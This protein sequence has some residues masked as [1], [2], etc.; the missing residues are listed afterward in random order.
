MIGILRTSAVGN[1]QCD[2]RQMMRIGVC[3][4]AWNFALRFRYISCCLF[5]WRPG[6]TTR[7]LKFI[8]K[9]MGDLHRA[10]FQ[11]DSRFDLT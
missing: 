1:L 9:E 5:L 2:E 10:K 3:P 7:G 4:S 6:E 8:V 11:L